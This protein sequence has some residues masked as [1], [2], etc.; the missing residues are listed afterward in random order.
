[1]NAYHSFAEFA[2]AHEGDVFRFLVYR[3]MFTPYEQDEKFADE[4]EFTDVHYTLGRIV[5]VI[6]FKDTGDC[7]VGFKLCGF[8]DTNEDDEWDDED[9]IVEYH[10]L[11]DIKLSLFAHD[12]KPRQSMFDLTIDIMGCN[13]E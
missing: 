7:M 8:G 6:E 4:S 10:N 1:M 3:R 12:A 13:K 11:N 5:D 2:S 9:T